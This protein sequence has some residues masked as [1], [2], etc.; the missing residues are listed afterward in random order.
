MMVA[1][2]RSA[3]LFSIWL[4]VTGLAIGVANTAVSIV[5]GAVTDT[6]VPLGLPIVA[7][8][9]EVALSSPPPAGGLEGDRQDTSSSRPDPPPEAAGPATTQAPA[10]GQPVGVGAP[11]T[12]D[13]QGEITT[14]ETAGGWVTITVTGTEVFLEAAG[15]QQGW[16]IETESTGPT[17]VVVKFK[18]PEQEITFKARFEAGAL[19]VRIES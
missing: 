13:A 12:T 4:A 3:T 11:S 6:P 16:K 15:P 8:A 10:A 5:R 7:P 14:Y 17:S 1:M 19:D 18:R 9:P 2:R